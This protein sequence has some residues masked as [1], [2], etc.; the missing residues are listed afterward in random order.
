MNC[1]TEII[2]LLNFSFRFTTPYDYLVVKNLLPPEKKILALLESVIDFSITMIEMRNSSAEEIF[3]GC[4][5][6]CCQEKQ[7]SEIC[8]T[9]IEATTYKW[10]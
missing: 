2:A 5:L 4:L 10:R 1:E 3:F 9:I 7:A 8:Y 6:Y